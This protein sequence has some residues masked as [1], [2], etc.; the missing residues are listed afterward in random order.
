MYEAQLR[1]SL[2][3]QTAFCWSEWQILEQG[4]IFPLSDFAAHMKLLSPEPWIPVEIL[5]T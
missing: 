1:E 3:D 5:L 4:K 2:L